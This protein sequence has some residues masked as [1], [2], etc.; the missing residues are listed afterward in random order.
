MDE[1]LI[2]AEALMYQLL[3]RDKPAGST[4]AADL[5]VAAIDELPLVTYT[6]DSSGLEVNGPGAWWM[7][8]TLTV[9]AAGG[10]AAFAVCKALHA[11]VHRWELPGVSLDPDIGWVTQVADSSL[12]SR[13]ASTD[14]DGRNVT[15]YAGAFDLLFRSV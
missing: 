10:D 3:Q 14:V 4:A 8:L 7:T 2:D 15:Q 12:F 5:D 11:A 6:L 9:Q 1:N 13:T